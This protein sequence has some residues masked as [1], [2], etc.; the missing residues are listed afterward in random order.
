MSKESAAQAGAREAWDFWLDQQPFTVSDLIKDA[1]SGA[2]SRWLDQH[3]AE[4]IAAATTLPDGT[5]SC[6]DDLLRSHFEA[7]HQRLDDDKD[8]T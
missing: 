8:A 6:L 5:P 7:L 2:V 1:V 4:I 3:K